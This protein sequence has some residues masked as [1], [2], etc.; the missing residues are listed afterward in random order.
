LLSRRFDRFARKEGI[1]RAALLEAVTRAERGLIDADLGGGVIKQRIARSGQGRSGGYRTLLVFR[2]GERAIFM[3]GFAKN[4][5]GNM[6]TGELSA[7][8][9]AAAVLLRLPLTTIAELV[10]RRELI[11]VER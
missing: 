10:E 4:D 11:E 6:T 8:K 7:V 1:T 9:E 3:H 5:Q 2:S